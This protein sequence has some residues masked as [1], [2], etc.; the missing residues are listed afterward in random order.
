MWSGQNDHLR[1]FSSSK[2]SCWILLEQLILSIDFLPTENNFFSQLL[3]FPEHKS[4][5]IKIKFTMIY[6]NMLYPMELVHK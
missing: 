2:G 1:F 3:Q 4:S 6:A 5:K